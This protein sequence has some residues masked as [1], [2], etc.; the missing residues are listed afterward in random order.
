MNDFMLIGRREECD[1]LDRCARLF[2]PQFVVVYGRRRVGKTYLV[3]TISRTGSLLISPAS[4]NSRKGTN[5]RASH[6]LTRFSKPKV[7]VPDDWNAAFDSL[8]DYLDSLPD[9]ERKTVFFDEFPWLDNGGGS[10]LK[11]FDYFWNQYGN[12]IPFHEKLHNARVHR[13]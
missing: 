11:A 4:T 3:D 5:L 12:A 7:V 9:S 1:E 8:G 10:F 6:E 2:K 13:L